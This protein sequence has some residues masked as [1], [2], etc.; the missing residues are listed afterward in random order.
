MLLY[1]G[2]LQQNSSRMS[3]FSRLLIIIKLQIITNVKEYAQNGY[4][5]ALPGRKKNG[6]TGR[7][8]TYMQVE[9]TT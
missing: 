3:S 4:I 5:R 9:F 2:I 8:Y 7:N 6:I 1:Q